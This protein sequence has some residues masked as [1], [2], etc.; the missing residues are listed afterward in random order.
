MRTLPAGLTVMNG[1]YGTLDRGLVLAGAIFASLPV[2]AVYINFQ[3][4]I[5]RGIT[6]TGMGGQ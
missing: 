6:L 2:L 4:R 5:L 1:A 3:R